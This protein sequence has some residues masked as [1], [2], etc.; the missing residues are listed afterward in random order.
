MGA[1]A[2]SRAICSQQAQ[3]YRLQCESLVEGNGVCENSA[4][5]CRGSP[6]E[7]AIA[8]TNH[9]LLCAQENNEGSVSDVLDCRASFQCDGSVIECG[10]LRIQHQNRCDN[11]LTEEQVS[12]PD[13]LANFREG[14]DDGTEFEGGEGVDGSVIDL[15]GLAGDL[16]ANRFGSSNGS[17]IPDA[18]FELL[19]Q[20]FLVPLSAWCPLFRLLG[21]LVLVL[22]YFV[23]GRIIGGAF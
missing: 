10:A 21:G 15:E 4:F 20:T 9:L 22:G 23:G 18:N 1:D 11:Q 12:S 13:N 2:A 3:D 16:N 19:G 7:C 6:T 8:E 5:I 17:C 14:V